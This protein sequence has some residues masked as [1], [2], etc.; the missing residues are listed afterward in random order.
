M[1]RVVNMRLLNDGTGRVC[2]HWFIRDEAGPIKTPGTAYMTAFGPIP[3]GGAVGR[4]ACNPEQNSVATQNNGMDF[5]PCLHS[6]DVR[7]AT[8]PDCLATDE[9]KKV[10][11]KLKTIAA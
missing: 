2:I 3:L 5:F 11:E 6:D 7:A 10:I 4:I 9:A 8:C 1:N